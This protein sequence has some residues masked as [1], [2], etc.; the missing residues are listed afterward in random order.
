MTKPNLIRQDRAEPLSAPSTTVAR[1]TP[2]GRAA[3]SVV[4]V[5]GEGGWRILRS[6]LTRADGAASNFFDEARFDRQ[7]F[8][9]F[10]FDERRETADEVILRRRARNAFELN[11]HGGDLVTARIIDCFRRHGAR[12][13]SG[14]EWERLVSRE[15]TRSGADRFSSPVQTLFLDPADEL[16][17]QTTTEE[18]AKLACDQ[19][20][21]WRRW[22][23]DFQKASAV[24]RKDELV[25]AIDVVLNRTL[26]R[27]LAASFVVALTGAPNV[28]KSSLLNAI[29]G[30]ERAVASPVIGTTRDLVSAPFTYKGWNYELVDS[31]GLRETSDSL[32]RAGISLATS[33][34]RRADA[35]ICVYD[36][37]ISRLE[38]EAIFQR[39]FP[40][41]AGREL[42]EILKTLNKTDLPPETWAKD[43]HDSELGETILV[44]A[45][46]GAGLGELLDALFRATASAHGWDES[47]LCQGTPLVWTTEQENFL[48]RLRALSADGLAIK[49][50][51]LADAEVR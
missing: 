3:V 20:E 24:W 44:S 19:R 27:Y 47:S 14:G 2:S 36:P 43:W 51:E 7:F 30:Y 42:P 32:E 45:R 6:R 17:T 26:G 40:E 8:G 4:G 13:V 5:V 23:A 35:V 9:L 50:A 34:V 39:S 38:Q 49:A 16:L 48:K 33:L 18:T 1:L 28:G 21:A 29:L 15:K 22:F 31:A 41:D 11:C 37:T 10:Y 46:N 12:V 25:A